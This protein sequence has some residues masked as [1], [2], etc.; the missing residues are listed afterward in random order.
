MKSHGFIVFSGIKQYK[1]GQ[2]IDEY[3]LRIT[4]ILI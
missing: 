3:Q 2:I 4:Q 1:H